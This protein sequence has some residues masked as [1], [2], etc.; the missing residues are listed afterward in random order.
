MISVGMLA[1]LLA[2]ELT[3]FVYKRGGGGQS[4][5]DSLFI[6]L[7]VALYMY[8]LYSKKK[9]VPQGKLYFNYFCLYLSKWIGTDR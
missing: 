3:K 4:P 7:G 8:T 5:P 9:P 6:R 1:A 2:I